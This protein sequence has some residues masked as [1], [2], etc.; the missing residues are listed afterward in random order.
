MKSSLASTIHPFIN[1]NRRKRLRR[2]QCFRSTDSYQ[3]AKHGI[4][5][6]PIIAS[7]PKKIHSKEN[8]QRPVSNHS[9]SGIRF[10]EASAWN[11]QTPKNK[12]Q[13]AENWRLGRRVCSL[14]CCRR[15]LKC[16]TTLPI[17]G[18]SSSLGFQTIKHFFFYISKQI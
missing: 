9:H 3:Q 1:C 7:D 12:Y 2:S 5:I 8:P 16:H 18:N 6:G 14:A 13:K 17:Y 10:E 11:H 15:W 4:Y